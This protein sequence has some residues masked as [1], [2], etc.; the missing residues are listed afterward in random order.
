M[1][2]DGTFL[3]CAVEDAA[4]SPPL[5]SAVHARR[6]VKAPGEES[7]EVKLRRSLVVANFRAS[8]RLTSPTG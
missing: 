5:S 2:L 6:F 4:S 7:E 3:A 8:V 1:L